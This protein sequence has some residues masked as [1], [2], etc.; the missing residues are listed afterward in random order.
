MESALE[1]PYYID[2]TCE[3]IKV[4]MDGTTTDFY[5]GER[6]NVTPMTTDEQE[7]YEQFVRSI[8]RIS[9]GNTELSISRIIDEETAYFFAGDHSAEQCADM[10]Q[11]RVSIMLSEQS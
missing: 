3:N 5:S 11:N 1:K 6:I 9:S 7:K 2:A 10:I 4:Y 8:T